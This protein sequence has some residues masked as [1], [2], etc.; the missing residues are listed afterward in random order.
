MSLYDHLA[1]ECLHPIGI[2]C[3]KFQLPGVQMKV[4]LNE[5]KI[6]ALKK[7]CLKASLINLR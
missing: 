3:V 6:K 5:A 2:S 1:V 4:P 7:L